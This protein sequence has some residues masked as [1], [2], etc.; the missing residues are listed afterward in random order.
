MKKA[1]YEVVGIDTNLIKLEKF[2]TECEIDHYSVHD[3]S[4]VKLYVGKIGFINGILF[5]TKFKPS[6]RKWIVNRI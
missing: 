4:F 1:R 2:L 3:G 5:L 6:E